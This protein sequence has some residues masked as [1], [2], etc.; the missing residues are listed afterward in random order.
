MEKSI[1]SPLPKIFLLPF[2]ALPLII[3]QNIQEDELLVTVLPARV[4][5]SKVPPGSPFKLFLNWD[6]KKPLSDQYQIFLHFL[7]ANDRIVLQ[8]DHEPPLTQ[9]N[10]PQFKGRISYER[11]FIVPKD[12]PDGSYRIVLGLYNKNGRL[13]LKAGKGVVEET[14][15]RYRVGTLIVDSKA[16]PAPPD[17]A[18]KNTLDLRGYELV[19]NEDFNG[20]LDVSPWGPGTRWIAHTPWHGD[21]GDA[22]FADPTPD[23]PFTIQNGILRIEARKDEEFAKS[24]PWK[25]S[26]RSG[27]L[28][29]NDPKGQGFSLRYGYFEMRA[30][31]P[32]GKGVWP[33]FWLVSSYDRTN[34]EAGKDG[35]IEIDVIEYYGFPDS[36]MSTVHIWEPK[37]HRAQG[38]MITTRPYEI[39]NDFHN[40]GCMVTPEW[41]IMY[42]DGVEVWRVK[43]PPEHNKPL[44]I[45][46]NLAL[47]GGWPINEVKSPT[48]MFVDWVR[49]YAKKK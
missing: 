4:I 40:Y 5:P 34:P 33:A 22:A 3:G 19:F 23:F 28:C 27:L 26:W 17:T 37:P 20:P 8:G 10:L 13:K 15:L 6:V 31:L 7:D 39:S 45:L 44:M 11:R 49:A 14:G 41:I 9:T 24:D 47:G 21:F 25:R 32:A 42:F 43:T 38:M 2:L 16:S 30:K 36:Y 18:G 46:L 48:Y 35:S 29:S 12:L 1:I